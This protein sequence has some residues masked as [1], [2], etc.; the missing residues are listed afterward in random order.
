MKTDEPRDSGK[1][2]HSCIE[3]KQSDP[4]LCRF[5]PKRNIKRNYKFL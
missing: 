1:R 5:T 3:S 2:V 4:I